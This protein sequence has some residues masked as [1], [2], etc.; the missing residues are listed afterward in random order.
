MKTKEK[1]LSRSALFKKIQALSLEDK[2][3]LKEKLDELLRSE[4]REN[5]SRA[6]ERSWAANTQFSEEEIERD[7]MDAIREYRA[8]KRDSSRD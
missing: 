3:W 4:T 6:L 8:Q 5:F 1:A 2:F 7:V